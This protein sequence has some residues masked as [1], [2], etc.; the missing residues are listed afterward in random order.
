MSWVDKLFISLSFIL[1]K[2]L[3]LGINTGNKKT[4]A[5][6][7]KNKIDS[8]QQVLNTCHIRDKAKEKVYHEI[9]RVKKL[10]FIRCVLRKRQEEKW[11]ID[12]NL[13]ELW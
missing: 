3:K 5:I 8:H 6:K 12:K 4:I 10:L 11:D 13:Q 7:N 1:F 9:G 2:K